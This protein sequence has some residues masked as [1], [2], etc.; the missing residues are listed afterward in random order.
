MLKGFTVPKSPFGQAALT[1]RPPWHY[2]GDVVGVEFWTDPDAMAATLPNG[3]SP[4]PSSSGRAVMMFLDWQFTA[5]DDEYLEPARYQH[6]E[7][8]ILVDSI[9]R[10]VPLMWCPYIYVDNDAALARG[11]SCPISEAYSRVPR[12][13]ERVSAAPPSRGYPRLGD[14]LAIGEKVDEQNC[15]RISGALRLRSRVSHRILDLSD[16]R[17]V[18]NRSELMFAK[19]NILIFKTKVIPWG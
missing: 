7:A 2:D 9:Y 4:D 11:H 15:I 8:F 5:Q 1:P 18:L 10:D 19:C 3:L 17:R 13:A 16:A 6:R 12:F 14:V